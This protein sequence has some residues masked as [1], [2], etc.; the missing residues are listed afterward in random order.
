MSAGAFFHGQP[1]VR[2]LDELDGGREVFM[3][4]RPFVV[5]S[6]VLGRDVVVPAGFVS[7]GESVPRKVVGFTGRASVRSGLPHD[8]LYQAHKVALEDPGEITKDQADAVYHE[9]MLA[10]GVDEV[11]ARIRYEAVARFGQTAWES[12]PRRLRVLA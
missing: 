10:A 11:F 4:L 7:D 9:L 3:L 2:F 6:A 5:S 12:G 8:W 1:E